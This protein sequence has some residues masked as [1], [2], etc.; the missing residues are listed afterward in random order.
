[1]LSSDARNLTVVNLCKACSDGSS[2]LMVIQCNSSNDYGYVLGQAYI[3]VLGM[4]LK[5]TEHYRGPGPL[6]CGA[7]DIKNTAV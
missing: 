5:Y 1:M 6:R 4:R 7:G 2:D 3:N